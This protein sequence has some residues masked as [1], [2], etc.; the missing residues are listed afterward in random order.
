MTGPELKT[1]LT[2]KDFASDQE[3]RWC[4]GC[5]DYP[6]LV[7]FQRVLPGLG[8]PREKFVFVSGIGC[9]S[10]FPYYMNTYGMHSIH[11]RAP[12]IASG[13]KISNPDLCVWVITGDGDGLSI[14]SLVTSDDN[15]NVIPKSPAVIASLAQSDIAYRYALIHGNAFAVLGADY[16]VHNQNG[17]LDLYDENTGQGTSFDQAMT[18][19]KCGEALHPGQAKDKCEYSGKADILIPEDGPVDQQCD[20]KC[21]DAGVHIQIMWTFR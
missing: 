13:I 20:H 12:A 21:G 14:G 10:R 16:T 8:I 4:P 2:R 15:G 1:A 9:S 18:R 17:E 3:V 7:R 6:I 11:G 19:R 5:G